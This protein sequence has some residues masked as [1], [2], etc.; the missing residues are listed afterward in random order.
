MGEGDPIDAIKSKKNVLRIKN[1]I[2][3]N[4]MIYVLL[5]EQFDLSAKMGIDINGI[6]GGD[7]FKNFVV[8]INYNSRRLV[9]YN[10]ES[11]EY[12]KC[13]DCM[14]FPLDFYRNKPLILFVSYMSAWNP[15]DIC[16]ISLKI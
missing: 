10:P 8:K 5:G 1:I 11:Y 15:P 16:K 3:P 7:L 2:S 13:K 9:F 4:Q 6:I 12:K 14:S